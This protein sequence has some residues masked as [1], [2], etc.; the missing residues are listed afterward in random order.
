[1]ITPFMVPSFHSQALLHLCCPVARLRDALRPSIVDVLVTMR[2]TS[3]M[4]QSSAFDIHD[5]STI[6]EVTRLAKFPFHALA[7]DYEARVP[8]A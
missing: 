4:P 8:T 1:M 6:D 7:F 3:I 5:K 2:S